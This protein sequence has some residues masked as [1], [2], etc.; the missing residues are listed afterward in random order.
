MSLLIKNIKGLVQAGENFLL[1]KSGLEMAQLPVIENAFL[2][3]DKDTIGNYGKMENIPEYQGAE[4]IDATGRFVFP[5]FVDSHSHIVFAG[6]RE[7]EFV[8]KIEGLSYQEIAKKGGGILNSANLLRQTSE[9]ELF[10]QAMVRV[11]EVIEMG[12]GALEIKSGYGLTVEDEIK[13][14]RVAQKIKNATDLTIKT[15]FLGAHAV[16]SFVASKEAYIDSVINEMIPRI[17]A[18]NLADYCDV[19]CEEGFFTEKE[20]VAI[21]EAGQKYGIKS[22]VHANQLSFSGGVQAGVKVKAVSVDHLETIGENEIEALKN[23]STI[24]TL[25][26]GAAFFLRMNYPPAR[27]M[28]KEGLSIALASDYNPGSAPSGNMALIL[29]LACIQMK[30]TPEEAMNAAT[31]NGA[32][33]MEVSDRLGTISKGKLANLFITKPIPSYSFLPYA[34]GSDLIEKVILKGRV[35]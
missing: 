4:V 2:Y 9:D 7:S 29:S 35:Q 24:A 10:E 15:T 31:I 12:T 27:E 18:E 25:L 8:D 32:Y 26:P 22:K 5:S 1:R 13:M 17:A 6:S 11:R 20:T 23:S 21:L 28:L 14:L 30:L 16:P 34:F 33:A 19:F 3:I